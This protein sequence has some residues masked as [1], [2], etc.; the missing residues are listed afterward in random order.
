MPVQPPDGPLERQPGQRV[1]AVVVLVTTAALFAVAYYFSHFQR[2]AR[3]GALTLAALILVLAFAQAWRWLF[4]STNLRSFLDAAF[5]FLL[6]PAVYALLWLEVDGDAP[7]KYAAIHLALPITASVLLAATAFRTQL[8]PPARPAW[9]VYGTALLASAF[10][11]FVAGS[12]V[13]LANALLQPQTQ[14]VLQGT[15]LR[16]VA[17][18]KLA[19]VFQENTSGHHTHEVAV[20][21]EAFERYKPGDAVEVHATRGALGLYY[22]RRW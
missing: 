11:T 21:R 6:A 2:D 12:Y 14:V 16:K 10:L 22:W 8:F 13:A 15:L 5:M 17:G 1:V 3:S 9:R 18:K 19:L 20:S 7:F 4:V